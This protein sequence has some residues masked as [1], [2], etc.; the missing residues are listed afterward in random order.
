MVLELN[1]GVKLKTYSVQTW[2]D[3]VADL[4][5]VFPDLTGDD[6]VRKGFK[7][8]GILSFK[9]SGILNPLDYLSLFIS[10]SFSIQIYTG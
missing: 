10:L 2:P 7:Y 1:G 3:V 5:R 6:G 4:E 8:S 9:Y